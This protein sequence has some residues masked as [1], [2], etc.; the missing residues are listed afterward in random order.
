LPASTA[1]AVRILAAALL[2]L[3]ACGDAESPGDPVDGGVVVDATPAPAL[4][5][6]PAASEL[7]AEARPRRG[8]WV[9]CEGSQRILEHPDRFSELI[10]DARRLGATDL[11]V[12]VYRGGRAWFDSSLA[13]A[14]PHE[15]IVAA[16]GRD[17][18][19]ELIPLA[20]DAGLRVHAWV[21][22][23][24]LAG[25]T[26]SRLVRE[27]GRSAVAVDRKGRSV[28]D[29]PKLEVPEPD[30]HWYRMGTPAVWLDPAAPGVAEHLTAIYLELLMQYPALDGV[31]LDYIRYPD[32]LPFVPGSRFGVGLD[33]GYGE[34][35]RAR[36]R[37]ETGLEA[38]L[39]D[40]LANASRWDSWR[41]D[42]LTAL[43]AMIGA[44]LRSIDAEVAL[45]V[46]GWAY[47][48]RAY[49]ALGQDWRGWLDDELI[50]FAVPMAYTVDDALLIHLARSFAGLPSGDRIWVGLGVWLF[51]RKPERA[52]AQVEIVRAAGA[53]G[54]ALF[55]WDSIA[56][57]PA[58]RDA[59]AAGAGDGP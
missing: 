38:P 11:F 39:G 24:S 6:E 5:V 29:Y 14:S 10:D 43:V 42:K 59:L 22:V 20:Q 9:L 34:E 26:D 58:L 18:L 53:G 23:L 27:L 51:E 32:V 50:D 37:S 52:V 12:Q 45:S 28:L 47:A 31:H 35:T 25:N 1:G 40:S 55:S 54:D 46:A 13:D 15:A 16:T 21:N 49:L 8:L 17:T 56:A 7:G 36:F 30:R 57:A 19:A 41:R 3:A 44:A 4:P 33:F 48:D 2:A